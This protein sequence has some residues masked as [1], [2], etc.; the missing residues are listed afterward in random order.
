MNDREES[1]DSV[2]ISRDVVEAVNAKLPW[3]RGAPVIHV[4]DV[5]TQ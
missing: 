2:G 5:K 3:A 4:E 1:E